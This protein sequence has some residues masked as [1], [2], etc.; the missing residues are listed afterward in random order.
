MKF[1]FLSFWLLLSIMLLVLSGCGS[2][3]KIRPDTP[4]VARDLV[5]FQGKRVAVLAF[6]EPDTEPGLGNTFAATLHW[7]VLR[8][9]PFGYASYHPESVWFGP[10]S[11]R[12]EELATAGAMASDLGADLA[13]V[14]SVDRFAYGRTA[15]SV[16][17]LSIWIIDSISGEVIYAERIRALGKVGNFPP[18]WEPKLSR[19]PERRGMLEKVAEELVHRMGV[20]W[21]RIEGPVP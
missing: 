11:T 6:R 21:D 5:P 14:G 16:L 17:D 13:I 19:A 8:K 3:V 10:Q 20:R 2:S 18:V 15:D 4:A 1:G 12:V 9:G 7:E